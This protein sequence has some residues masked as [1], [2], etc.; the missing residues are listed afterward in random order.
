MAYDATDSSD[1]K[2]HLYLVKY[3]NLAQMKAASVS[4][5][6]MLPITNS[7]AYESKPSFDAV[8]WF[9]SIADSEITLFYEY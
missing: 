4:E 8:T 3:D 9:G 7:S 6:V 2:V 5:T 1:S